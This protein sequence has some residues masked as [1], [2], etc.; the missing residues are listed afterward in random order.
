MVGVDPRNDLFGVSFVLG[1]KKCVTNDSMLAWQIQYL[2]CF[3]VSTYILHNTRWGGRMPTIH[4][5]TH[6]TVETLF[7]FLLNRDGWKMHHGSKIGNA[8]ELMVTFCAAY[9]SWSVFL[10]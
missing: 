8:I 5:L 10:S 6:P 4:F 3:R 1:E 2:F 9:V 7:M